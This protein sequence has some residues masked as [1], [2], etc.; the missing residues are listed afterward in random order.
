MSGF[1]AQS[2]KPKT[3]R[4][5]KKAKDVTLDDII[6]E[7]ESARQ[8]AM[9]KQNAGAMVSATMAKAKLLGLDKLQAETPANQ[10]LRVIFEDKAEF[11]QIA[12]DLL[13]K[14]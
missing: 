5:I 1:F 6:K 7:L 8:I 3:K 13:E 12:K 10:C 4:A 14:I 11:E 2:D 9:L